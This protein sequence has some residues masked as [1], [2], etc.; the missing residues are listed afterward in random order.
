MNEEVIMLIDNEMKNGNFTAIKIH[1]FN[2]CGYL[3]H[4][5]N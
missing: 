3:W 1:F 4:I 5:N 2:R